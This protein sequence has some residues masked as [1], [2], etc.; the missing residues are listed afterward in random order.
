MRR[1]LPGTIPDSMPPGSCST[2]SK[3][4]RVYGVG[5]TLLVAV[6]VIAVVSSLFWA[7]YIQAQYLAAT[8]AL[9]FSESE[10]SIETSAYLAY[11]SLKKR[12]TIE[13]QSV[14]SRALAL[15]PAPLKSFDHPGGIL[16]DYN[17]DGTYLASVGKDG[18]VRIWRTVD[19]SAKDAQEG[20]ELHIAGEVGDVAWTDR[21]LLVGSETGITE[22][23]PDPPRV[24][25]Q[26]VC[27]KYSALETDSVGDIA[28]V[29]GG[30]LNLWLKE[31][32]R[33]PAFSIPAPQGKGTA[34]IPR[35]L[36]LALWENRELNIGVVSGVEDLHGPP[37][38]SL[39]PKI[40]PAEQGA[41]VQ[42]CLSVYS[43]DV[44]N[45]VL[46]PVAQ[47]CAQGPLGTRIRSI[48]F[49]PKSRKLIVAQ[50]DGTVRAWSYKDPSIR[51]AEVRLTVTE[52]ITSL[53]EDANFLVTTEEGA[54]HLWHLPARAELAR[55]TPPRA[56]K[57]VDLRQDGSQVAGLT[58]KGTILRWD[59]RK[60][61]GRLAAVAPLAVINGASFSNDGRSVVLRTEDASMLFDVMTGHI[62][63]RRD[64]K[65]P[66]ALLLSPDGTKML[67][68]DDIAPDNSR[69]M[70]DRL[71][72][73]PG[74]E[75]IWPRPL[76]IG[77]FRSFPVFGEDGL[78]L[79]AVR[80][81]GQ[82]RTLLLCSAETGA[83][84]HSWDLDKG[85]HHD[86]IG[87]VDGGRSV[88]VRSGT[89]FHL[90]HNDGGRTRLPVTLSAG[91]GASSLSSDGRR[92]AVAVATGV[93]LFDTDSW[94]ESNPIPATGLTS[95]AFGAGASRLL[96]AG[97]DAV[98]RVWDASKQLE[99]ARF[100][101]L[102]ARSSL[103][104]DSGWQRVCRAALPS[105]EQSVPER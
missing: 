79:A 22:I 74:A 42:D 77:T 76:D 85:T 33:M 69:L 67:M 80:V 48:K 30:Q 93:R 37:A 25:R 63:W 68:R 88:L 60:N 81:H 14:L 56:L 23:A 62:K 46:R 17:P 43:L 70:L 45:P 89:D 64:L 27:E 50:V 3:N 32:G 94:K 6:V 65:G 5:G 59:L 11:A 41:D 82:S 84:L 57:S 4:R 95:M 7:N 47:A 66:K 28:A 24:V 31:R 10:N 99:I 16:V 100:L 39:L 36:A 91:V 1:G 104:A 102:Q 92:L 83:E 97:T 49:D 52:P 98:V 87:F 18:S 21:N 103:G 8:A 86:L 71:T 61:L 75:H 72:A 19:D 12:S 53:N 96:T 105:D 90:F 34:A 78:H 29:C 55:L 2:T 35:M 15:M 51:D 38:P 58:D 26:L 54:A 40:T 73:Q 13:A 101:D 9:M 20:P 44:M